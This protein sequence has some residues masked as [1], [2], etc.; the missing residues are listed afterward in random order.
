MQAFRRL[1]LDAQELAAMSPERQ[2]QAVAVAVTNIANP[3]ERAA[4]AMELF[5]RAGARAIPAMQALAKDTEKMNSKVIAAQSVDAFRDLG[6]RGKSLSGDLKAGWANMIGY[7]LHSTF[8]FGKS[9]GELERLKDAQ[10]KAAEAANRHQRRQQALND[11]MERGNRIR[12]RANALREQSY[13]TMADARQ[14]IEDIA[15]PR[16]QI[17]KDR[18]RMVADARKLAGEQNW[19]PFQLAGEE[20]WIRETMD[21]LAKKY[22]EATAAADERKKAET[23]A[24]QAIEATKSAEEKYSETV[25]QAAEWRQ[26]NLITDAQEAAIRAKAQKDLAQSW[27]TS[28]PK[29]TPLAM[30]G[31]QQEYQIIASAIE[32]KKAGDAAAKAQQERLDRIHRVLQSIDNKTAAVQVANP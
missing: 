13:A 26:K 10:D 11:E 17:E 6:A 25:R 22:R 9:Q 24:T 23:A 5:G 2:M 29:M 16:N 8:G 7:A 3:A 14:S 31:S 32:G 21:E 30:K 15:N 28:E 1:K 4:L 19:D 27:K 12:E 18:D 20:R